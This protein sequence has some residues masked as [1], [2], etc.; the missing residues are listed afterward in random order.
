VSLPRPTPAA[1][2][3]GSPRR[4]ACRG[5]RGPPEDPRETSHRRRAARRWPSASRGP[6]RRRGRRAGRAGRR[7]RRARR[8]EASPPARARGHGR[9]A[10]ARRARAVG[11][12]GPSTRPERRSPRRRSAP[13]GPRSRAPNGREQHRRRAL[14]AVVVQLE[15]GRRD[16]D[17]GIGQGDPARPAVVGIERPHSR[18]ADGPRERRP[19]RLDRRDRC[20]ARRPVHVELADRPRPERVSPGLRDATVRASGQVTPGPRSCARASPPG[21]TRATPTARRSSSPWAR[22]SR[23]FCSKADPDR[24][25]S[26]WSARPGRR[27]PVAPRPGGRPLPPGHRRALRER[28]RV[29]AGLPG[30]AR[31]V[32]AGGSAPRA[33]P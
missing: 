26:S 27:R 18:G 3:R 12:R 33:T 31:A 10:R 23:S 17:R 11:R 20:P 30:P 22:A 8:R 4:A 28:S 19:I 25:C 21:D 2:R 14:E 32:R 15:V 7:S 13:A 5:S 16:A 29:P 24:P 1:G 6:R 9:T